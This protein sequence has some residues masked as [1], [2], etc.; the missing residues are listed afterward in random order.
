MDRWTK[1]LSILNYDPSTKTVYAWA[2]TNQFRNFLLNNIDFEVKEKDNV[3]G[4]QLMS[5]Q[6]SRSSLLSTLSFPLN[7][8]PTYADYAQ[9]MLD[10]ETTYPSLC[11]IVDIGGTTEGVG[12]GDKRLLFAKLSANVSTNEQEPRMMYTSSMHGDEIAGYPMM[13]ELINYLLTVYND[14]GHVDHLR[15][16]NLLDTTEIWIN[17]NAN[18]DGT[19]YSDPTNTSVANA[20]R[21]NANGWDLNRNY[22]DNIGGAH[23]DGNS[24][25]E[26]ETQYFMSLADTYHFVLSANF[27]GGTEVVNYPWDNTYTRH[28][29]DSWFFLIS[30]EY[31]VNCQNNSPSGYMDAMYTNYVWPGVTNG[32]DWYRVEGGR[33]D[34]MNYYQQCKETTIE[35][36]DVKT[37]P[38]SQ[39]NAHWNYNKEALI[40]YLEQGTYGFRGVVKDGLTNNPIE[41]TI[42]L[43]GHDDV[44]SH[45]ITE[46]PFGD[47][48]RPT[49]AGTY[50]I[51]FEADCYQSFTLPN[52]SI[53]NYQ[54][55]SIPDIMLTPI[56][57]EAPTGLS[58]SNI[59]SST[60]T[61]S[62]D[63]IS[64]ASYD[65]RYRVVGTSTWTTLSTNNTSVNLTNLSLTTQYEVQVRSNCNTSVS[66]YSSSVIFNTIN[67]VT[68]HEGYF[69]TGWDGW[70]D[71]GGDCSR[72]TG[73]Y[74]YEGIYSI[75]LRDNSGISSAMTSPTFD[76]S[77]YAD[78][79]ISFYYYSRS[80]E[81]GEDFWL[82]YYNGSTWTTIDTYVS[83]TDFINNS[84]SYATFTLNEAQ[85]NLASNTQFRIQCDA[86]GNND[87][88]YI[89][90]VI[91]KGTPS[92]PDVI[93]P[94]TPLNLNASNTTQTTTNLSWDASTDNIGVT[95][96]DVYQDGG[97][98]T[99]VTGTTYQV[100]G[101]SAS[102]S[103]VFYVIARDAAG[104]SS[105]A[106]NTTNITTLDPP[107][108]QAPTTPTN[109]VASNTSYNSTDL[110]WD[111]STDN[112]GVTG[113]DV[114]QD[115]GFVTNVSG[116]TY[117]A[118]GLSSNTSYAFYVIARDAAG[119]SS[120]ASNTVNVT[121]D[122]FVDTEAP[123]TP[124]GLA[125]SN[126]TDSSTDLSWNAS[127]DNIGVTGY[128]VYQDGG[129]VTNVSGTTYQVS[130][131]SESTT[132][133]F[134]VIARD[135]SGNS[136]SA[137]NTI[138]E[139]TLAT[140]TC[141][142]GIQN[143]DETGVDCGGSC[144]PCEPTDVI[145]NQGYFESGWDNW[146]DGGKDCERYS[147]QNSYE[148]IYSIQL[149]DNSGVKSS[150]TLSNVD[151]T[152]F[153]QIEIDFY[154][155][156]SSM[157]NGEDFWLR[158]FD[159]ST[160]TTV[161]SWISGVNINNNSF[162]NATVFINSSQYNFATNAGF[163][164]QIDASNRTDYIYIDQVTITGTSGSQAKNPSNMLVEIESQISD[165]NKNILIYPNPVSED[166]LNIEML[167]AK[168]FSYKITNIT[169]RTIMN[170]NSQG[171]INVSNLKS[172][173]YFIEIKNED[174][175]IV[176]RFIR[177]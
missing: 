15:I 2:N 64:G 128:D 13:L 90:E 95:G 39:L 53:S 24:N 26:L 66:P 78:V 149:R 62:W 17:P 115:G 47:F 11:E 131:L 89:D 87:Y 124:T 111:A 20:R 84:F 174:E 68:L 177:E 152:P 125:A 162:Y 76:L 23:P 142:D 77:P 32:A 167:E 140:P 159:G 104:N 8:Y 73:S 29:D 145:L 172:G 136:S 160:W 134:Y 12:G 143:G 117:Q 25:Y 74:S 14:T 161:D 63:N 94:S 133:A 138:N 79:E 52:Q 9:Q 65:Y 21:A 103:Y 19:Y 83:G 55:V 165:L 72:Y 82:R 43:V 71:G 37:I 4:P 127:S 44:N 137:S 31:A 153:N 157:E 33:Q 57:S 102:T 164:F 34:Y 98:I 93:S 58:V 67:T 46:L 56:A 154:F 50:D 6:L 42:T 110:S 168:Q 101:L 155:Y 176:K 10:F 7:A 132:Y 1:E 41:A 81:N 97:F 166:I 107:D 151:V 105:A 119:N 22:P 99:N 156:V 3:V 129:F 96:Y 108:T 38:A 91:I 69:E 112:V 36:S 173:M 130:G 114:Y 100:S 54:T 139:T 148:G 135:A 150:M 92:G 109:L 28:P 59:Q 163:R 75:Q 146:I 113:Y 18:P 45:T 141:S 16:K 126:T 123:T 61:V 122:V 85:Y 121:T 116:T 144:Q 27:H 170:G 48:Y 35:L 49:I 171:V 106:S 51:L 30:K 175:I 147:G 86:S 120:S 169:G 40:E 118:T 70:S 88:I 158:Y 80:M 5:N 60:A